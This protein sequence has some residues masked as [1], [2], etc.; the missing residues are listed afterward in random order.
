ML[1]P[2]IAR[3]AVGRAVAIFNSGRRISIPPII[4][5]GDAILAR[6]RWNVRSRRA[7]GCRRDSARRPD[8]GDTPRLAQSRRAGRMHDLPAL[9]AFHERIAQHVRHDEEAIFE[10]A[11]VR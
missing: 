2:I 7:G 3:K 4:A 6:F 1:T 8:R 11:H 10:P 9:L 5:T